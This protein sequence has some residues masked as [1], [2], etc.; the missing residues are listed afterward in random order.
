MLYTRTAIMRC[1]SLPRLKALAPGLSPV[2]RAVRGCGATRQ[3]G[4]EAVRDGFSGGL[5]FGNDDE[6]R[7]ILADNYNQET[8]GTTRA[9]SA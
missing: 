1:A 5:D 6:L 8:T 7:L 9:Q 3:G 2:G 4:K